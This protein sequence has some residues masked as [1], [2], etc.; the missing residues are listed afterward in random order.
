MMKR[1]YF[2]LDFPF[3][4]R[5]FPASFLLDVKDAALDVLIHA[6]K[7]IQG[8]GGWSNEIRIA[9]AATLARAEGK[10]YGE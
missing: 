9:T 5:I 10:I 4:A 6:G 2:I 3:F 1:L 8:D 7:R